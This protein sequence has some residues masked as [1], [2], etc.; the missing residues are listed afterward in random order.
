MQKGFSRKKSAHLFLK[1]V[2]KGIGVVAN[3]LD[4][5]NSMFPDIST[6]TT[7]CKD[8][9]TFFFNTK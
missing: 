1:D 3:I 7:A 5:G 6:L 2:L 8:G 9:I 4:D